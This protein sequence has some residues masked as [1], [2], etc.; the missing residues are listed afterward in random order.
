[1]PAIWLVTIEQRGPT[2]LSGGVYEYEVEAETRTQAESIA[3][4]RHYD[5]APPDDAWDLVVT[6]EPHSIGNTG[7]NYSK[8][9]R[10]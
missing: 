6:V 9:P 10:Y 4:E 2:I 5:R 8:V 1:M 3:R 7:Y